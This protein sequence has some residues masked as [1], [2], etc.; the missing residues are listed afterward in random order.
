M[1][2]LNMYKDILA[3][4]WMVKRLA[5]GNYYTPLHKLTN[6]KNSP[7]NTGVFWQLVLTSYCPKTLILQ[8]SN[9]KTS[10]L[11][12]LFIHHFQPIT[13][14]HFLCKLSP[15]APR[16]LANTAFFLHA[17]CLRSDWD[18]RCVN[19]WKIACPNLHKSAWFADKNVFCHPIGF[20]FYLCNHFHSPV[21]SRWHSSSK[22]LQSSPSD[23]HSFKLS[24]SITAQEL[25]IDILM[26]YASRVSF[27]CC[28]AAQ[29][30]TLTSMWPVIHSWNGLFKRDKELIS[31]V[32]KL[33]AKTQNIRWAGKVQTREM[34]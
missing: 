4:F 27:I 28:I 24:K 33:S 8:R 2:W 19:K 7:S 6:R 31:T 3:I 17:W 13:C 23:T 5:E 1:N 15:L 29:L 14:G 9:P 16:C 21:F 32:Q 34:H 26:V 30:L 22:H 25:C 12:N 20:H 18:D 10:D 11:A